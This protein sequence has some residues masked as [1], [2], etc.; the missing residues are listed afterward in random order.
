[1]GLGAVGMFA[2]FEDT[3]LFLGGAPCS[4]RNQGLR[5]AEANGRGCDGSP[6]GEE[7][8]GG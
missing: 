8:E 3:L 6:R 7:Y 4:E 1:M 5:S 2:V